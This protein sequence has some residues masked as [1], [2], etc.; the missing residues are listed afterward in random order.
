MAAAAHGEIK[1]NTHTNNTERE[2]EQWEHGHRTHTHTHISSKMHRVHSGLKCTKDDYLL[3]DGFAP[4]SIHIFL[5]G[6][7]F[8]VLL[9]RSKWKDCAV[10]APPWYAI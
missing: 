4:G 6:C 7:Y 3:A 5:F 8:R 1:S 9:L 10:N 2:R